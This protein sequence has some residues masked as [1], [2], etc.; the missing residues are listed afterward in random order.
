MTQKIRGFEYEPTVT[1]PADS[2][3]QST[4]ARMILT[5]GS[6]PFQ[7]RIVP[8]GSY[9]KDS[10]VLG[11]VPNFYLGR[12]I[13]IYLDSEPETIQP[14]YIGDM[15]DELE[16]CGYELKLS[17]FKD[18]LLFL[19]RKKEGNVYIK[20]FEV[21]FDCTDR[22]EFS[23]LDINITDIDDIFQEV[24]SIFDLIEWAVCE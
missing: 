24:D 7:I 6:G 23:V 19:A 17:T 1:Q 8:P 13:V 4:K 12:E 14:A 21:L 20:S 15:K 2:P 3:H 9:Y 10:V 18:Q 16:A 22:K 11:F 5:K